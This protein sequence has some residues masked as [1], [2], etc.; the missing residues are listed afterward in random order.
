MKRRS[1][2]PLLHLMLAM[3]MLVSQQIGLSHLMSHGVDDVRRLAG[4]ASV[5]ASSH[6]KDASVNLLVENSC[7]DCLSLTQL[8]AALPG[9]V[10]ASRQAVLDSFFILAQPLAWQSN[11]SPSPFHSRAPPSA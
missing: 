1:L 7:Q 5:S 4:K 11:V 2:I 10:H 6:A 8:G 9:H 3:V